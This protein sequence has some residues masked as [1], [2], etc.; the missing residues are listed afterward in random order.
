MNSEEAKEKI[1]EFVGGEMT[2]T[3]RLR[4]WSIS[5]Q[6]YWGTPIPVVYDPE[7]NPHFVGEENL[8]WLLP[9]DVDFVPTGTAPL[10]KSKELQERTERIF[11]KG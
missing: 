9:T 8:P 2:A 5:R 10:A 6:R 1:T 11:G 7:G 3:Y 4:D